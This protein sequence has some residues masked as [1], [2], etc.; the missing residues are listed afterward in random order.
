MAKNRRILSVGTPI[1]LSNLRIMLE[2]IEP[3][4]PDDCI[5]KHYDGQLIVEEPVLDDGLFPSSSDESAPDS[6]PAIKPAGGE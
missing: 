6:P 2:A 3:L 1:R 4:R 5:V